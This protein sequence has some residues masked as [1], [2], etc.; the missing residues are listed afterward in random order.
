MTTGGLSRFGSS[1][2]EYVSARIRTRHRKLLD[3]EEY[4]KL[5]R[6]GPSGIARFLEESEYE[7]EINA[8]GTRY[9]GVD[10]IEYALNRNIAKHFKDLLT[11]TSGRL[12]A[13]TASYLRKYDVWNLKTILRGIYTDSTPEEIEADMIRAGDLDDRLLDRLVE[14]DSIQAVVDGLEG[15]MYYDPLAEALSV[16][17]DTGTLIPLENALDRVFYTEMQS[18][19]TDIAE[20]EEP[21]RRFQ[22]FLEAEIDFRNTRNA[23]RLARSGADMDPTEYFIDGGQLYTADR[24]RQLVGNRDELIAYIRDSRYGE[25]LSTALEQLESAESL[26]QFEHALDAALLEY[27]DRLASVYPMSITA[28][29]S[30]ILA[31]EREIENIR[32]IA[33]GREVGLSEEE[34]EEQLV[35]L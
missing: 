12:H 33:R 9:G 29:L 25:T 15:T 26:M 35:M 17:T 19:L 8:L 2:P 32:A 28:V 20:G 16:Y 10:L 27:A 6:M 11:W 24:L 3:E 18:D 23:L 4:R 34:I 30:Y 1:N 14:A 22:Q 31:K 7:A 21:I 13:Q 5:I